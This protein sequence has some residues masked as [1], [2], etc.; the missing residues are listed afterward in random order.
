MPILQY[1]TLP[2]ANGKQAVLMTTASH[3]E[4]TLVPV[5]SVGHFIAQLESLNSFDERVVF[6]D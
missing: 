1:W 3:T 6:N 4:I 2:V 5:D